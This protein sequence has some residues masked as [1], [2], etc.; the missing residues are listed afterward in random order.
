MD[1]LNPLVTGLTLAVTAAII[2]IICA[3]MFALWPEGALA[4]FNAWSHGLDLGVLQPDAKAFTFGV[5][6]YGLFGVAVAGFL[7]GV[8][9][10]AIYNLF[11]RCCPK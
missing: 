8:V 10:A 1:K 5:F 6:F 7:T 4:F 2:H 11:Q 3:A 9:F